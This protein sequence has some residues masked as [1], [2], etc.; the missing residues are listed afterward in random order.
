MPW[1]KLDDAF[2][3]HEKILDRS[4]DAKLLHLAA[5]T[6]C[7]A[8][9][10]HGVLSPAAVRVC[11]AKVDISDREEV[12]TELL[13]ANLWETVPPDSPL[14]PVPP[15]SYQIHDFTVYNPTPEQADALRTAR[16]EED[17]RRADSERQR[18]KR[19]RERQELPPDDYDARHAESEAR[20]AQNVT[21]SVTCHENDVTESVTQAVTDSVTCHGVSSRVRPLAAA[22]PSPSPFPIPYPQTPAPDII[23]QTPIGPRKTMTTEGS[24]RNKNSPDARYL[25]GWEDAEQ[26]SP[27]ALLTRYRDAEGE[28]GE[29]RLTAW[30]AAARKPVHSQPAYLRPCILGWLRGEDPDPIAVPPPQLAASPTRSIN[31]A[32]AAKA[33]AIRAEH[34]SVQAALNPIEKETS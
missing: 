12:V 34:G 9:S 26:L 18:N 19:E 25:V 10:P 6:Y 22:F 23:P 1:L 3:D 30:L 15:G 8:R 4:K 5:L 16:R 29:E 7:A 2:F 11:A 20:H 32:A 14:Q 33:E 13:F 27:G 17:R 24:V 28:A 31:A 21:E